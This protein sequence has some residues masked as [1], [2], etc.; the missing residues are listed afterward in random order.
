MPLTPQQYSHLIVAADTHPGET[1]K[2]NEDRY[3]VKFFRALDGRPATLAVVCD[4]V[5]G[6]RAGEIASEMAVEAITQ[7]IA[8]SDS[9]DYQALFY[10]AIAQAS[11]AIADLADSN[12]DYKGM[13]T[14]AAV[15]LIHGSRL[16]TAYVGDSRLYLYRR[17]ADHLHQIS[18]DH[19]WL[20]AAV[21]HGLIK[22]E[23]A[24]T[25]P[26]QHVL[27]RHL[28]GRN[29]A[30][31]DF[32]IRLS[33]DESIEDSEAN[34][35]LTLEPGDVV[36]LCSDGLSDLVKADE[37]GQALRDLTPEQ[38]VRDLINLARQRGGF[39]NITVIVL[40]MPA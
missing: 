22:P 9:A 37:I 7:H 32:R 31:P 10:E 33:E 25:H 30:K 6:H 24:P 39:D 15:A 28:G 20:Q 23:D 8:N 4:G 27:L 16:F 34:Q 36:L 19:T 2:N 18:V 40:R 21:E 5:G 26:N 12:L 11:R 38:A 13:A 29:D 17:A 35:G 14:T 1:G 3:T